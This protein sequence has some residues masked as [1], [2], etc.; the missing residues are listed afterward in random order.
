MESIINDDS[1]IGDD[2]DNSTNALQNPI[3]EYPN[4]KNIKSLKIIDN[5]SA[6][7]NSNF[8]NIKNKPYG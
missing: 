8:K 7:Q 2:V 3:N 6:D 5:P 1:K 4:I